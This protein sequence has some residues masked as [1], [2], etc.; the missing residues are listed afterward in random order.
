MIQIVDVGKRF[1]A[2]L[3]LAGI[4]LDLPA[5]SRVAFVGANGS[6]KTTLLRCVL[7]L[8]RCDGNIRIGGVDVAADPR[9]ALAAVAY[10]P[11]IAPL[12][13]TPVAEVVLAHARI[14]RVN[15]RR[16]ASI[17]EELGLDLEAARRKR[18]RDLSGGTKQKL[19]AAM[20]LATD[21]SVLICDEPTA[22]LDT[23]ARTAFFRIL[24]RRPTSSVVILSSHRV[25]EVHKL[26][27]RVVELEEGSVREDAPTSARL[28]AAAWFR[29]EVELCHPVAASVPVFLASRGFRPSGRARFEARLPLH[30]KLDVVAELLGR[31]RAAVVDLTVA[32][33]DDLSEVAPAE[34]REPGLEE[35]A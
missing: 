35:V 7:G 14:R 26:V 28:S 16:L 34:G 1:G 6:G 4:S 31:H 23:A 12:L 8:T 3:A 2:V 25:E 29:V 18:F 15:P 20:A 30:E 11:Q 13:E 33:L 19:L 17:A 5:G 32:A 9:R 21:A 22:N 10:I 27:D 24:E